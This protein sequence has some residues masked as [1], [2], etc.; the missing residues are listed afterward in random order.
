MSGKSLLNLHLVEY[1][2]TSLQIVTNKYNI[3]A[4][5]QSMKVDNETKVKA[6]NSYLSGMARAKIIATFKIHPVT[7]WRWVKKYRRGGMKNLTKRSSYKKPWNK[8]SPVI[9]EKVVA[10]KE[11][12]PS[13]TVS[14]AYKILEQQKIKISRKGVWSIWQRY[15][16]T[17]FLKD[18]IGTVTDC[19]K[20]H[21]INPAV[22][23]TVETIKT[24]LNK[25]KIKE[26]AKI[27]N[28]LPVCPEDK[29]L[30][31]IP[32]HLL[33]LKRQ[34][35]RLIAESGKIPLKV[36]RTDARILRKK[37]ERQKMHYSSLRVGVEEGGALTW[38][39]EPKELLKLTTQLKK[40]A[41]GLRD[42]WLRYTISLMEGY[43]L[44]SLLRI[45]EALRRANA[46]KIIIRSLP[47]PYFLMGELTSLYYM[48]GRFR[49]AIYWAK[50]ALKGVTGDYR[51]DLYA[52][53]IG[54]L[55]VSGDYHS[56]PKILKEEEL[57]KWG[58]HTRLLLCE[59]L[60]YLDQG[61][62]Q[63]AIALAAE[64]LLKSKKEE[65]KA[66]FFLAIFILA[67]SHAA[68][69]ERQ[70]AN[71]LLRKYHPLLKK[72]RLEKEYHLRQILLED[73]H[74][75][76]QILHMPTLRLA[77]LFYCAKANMQV[78]H[79]HKA[80]RYARSQKLFGLF[81]RFAL[82]FP[83]PVIRLLKKGKDPKLPKRFLAM[84]I[85]QIDPPVYNIRFL[86]RLR[87]FKGEKRLQ[88]LRLN[89]KA[90]SFL[91]HLAITK[92]RRLLLEDLY[93]NCWP[94]SQKPS[95]NLSHLLARI[96]R[97]LKLHPHLLK[98]SGNFLMWNFYFTSD[99]EHFEET[100][101]QA[102]A[103]ERAGEWRFAKREYLQAF[104]LF[105]SEPF[106]KMYDPWSEQMR[107]V[108]LNKLETEAIHFAKQS[109][110]HKNKTDAKKVLEKATRIIPHSQEIRELA[111][112][113]NG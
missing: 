92:N 102:K 106:K 84:P 100:L 89:P 9:E 12:N 80:L 6:V 42:P 30:T 13:L 55:T 74:L 90:V 48:V 78:R 41:R 45:K 63:K 104:K 65:I 43:A 103:L 83:E 62:F 86:G 111:K 7:L 32:K 73:F 39:G 58:Y 28:S 51:K 15:G 4:S 56:I 10:L 71:I 52:S 3:S 79:Y 19:R 69:G 18:K 21:F 23:E 96:K 77:H 67:C 25:N 20:Y 46:C 107:R 105:R 108:I 113:L 72:Y 29:I 60:F 2:L 101:A 44:A 36:Y 35:E 38:L 47:N 27:I 49:E 59:A 14:K 88:R 31:A 94:K 93:H 109:L 34:A 66:F 24:M 85:F 26:A 17:G 33:S 82:F 5:V 50:K 57:D 61:D 16:L 53:L 87:I 70:R 91:I 68:A 11:M 22:I 40:K 1:L 95:R 64:A 75:P 97:A 112:R 99:Y 8:S 76:K 110:A 37:L 98:I 54:Y 81:A